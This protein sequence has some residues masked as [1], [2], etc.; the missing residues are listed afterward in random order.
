MNKWLWVASAV[1]NLGAVILSVE[2]GPFDWLSYI[3]LACLSL[4]LH[5]IG[6]SA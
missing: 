1:I 2:V 3:N 6:A 4:A 5:E